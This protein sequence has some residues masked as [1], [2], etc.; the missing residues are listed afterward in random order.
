MKRKAYNVHAG[1]LRVPKGKGWHFRPAPGAVVERV[2]TRDASEE[3]VEVMSGSGLAARLFV[4]LNVGAEQK[5]TEQNVI[6]VIAR[7]RREQGA[8]PNATILFQRGIYEDRN[9]N[10][11]SE[12]SL[13]IIIFAMAEKGPEFTGDMIKLA[14]TLVKELEQE[15]VILE[16][17]KR[18]V[19]EQTYWVT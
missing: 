9:R 6:D 13:Q 11:V 18:G 1:E 4:G 17:Q 16:I 12:P 7:V 3:D 19:S 14:E 10:I 15:A 2:G 5:W 8:S